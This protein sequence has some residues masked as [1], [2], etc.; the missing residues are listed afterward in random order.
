[1]VKPSESPVKILLADDS[2]TMHR[3]VALAIRKLPW[4]LITCD[5]GQDA[6][7][8]TLEQSP[9]VVIAD[10]DMPGLT[11]AELC[12]AIRAKPNLAH[13]KLILLCGSFDQIDEARLEKIPADGRLWKPFESHVL[14]ALVD[15][16][17]RNPSA[18]EGSDPTIGAAP[19]SMGDAAPTQE[20]SRAEM[21]TNSAR[22]VVEKT[23]EPAPSVTAPNPNEAAARSHDELVRSMTQ[24]TFSIRESVLP[25]ADVP[26]SQ[27]TENLWSPDLDFQTPGAEPEELEGA[28]P[29]IEIAR[30]AASA[31]SGEGTDSEFSIY[32]DGAPAA[33]SS[34]DFTV[35]LEEPAQA[36]PASPTAPPH[37]VR[38]EAWLKDAERA[39]RDFEASASP[40]FDPESLRPMVREEIERAF[41]GWLKAELEKTLSHVIAEIDQT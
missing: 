36:A 20:I 7:R 4:Q 13:I 2:V 35:E 21:N 32:R 24:E 15:A 17:L 33:P 6:L 5:N 16:L 31:K 19:R 3:A 1:M 37:A 22:T 27:A 30:S 11:G 39:T 41:K 34:G 38:D 26:T 28:E 23:L 10:L 40:A 9:D 25:V 8:L 29:T 14:T 12:Q 18:R